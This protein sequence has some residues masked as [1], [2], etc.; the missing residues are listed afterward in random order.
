MIDRTR[1]RVQRASEPADGVLA[2]PFSSAIGSRLCGCRQSAKPTVPGVARICCQLEPAQRD[3]VALINNIRKRARFT[4]GQPRP[5]GALPQSAAMALQCGGLL[6]LQQA[7]DPVGPEQTRVS[8]VHALVQR[9]RRRYGEWSALPF[10]M[11]L[12]AVAAYRT[13]AGARRSA[14]GVRRPGDA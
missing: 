12:R 7:L 13:G 2:C 10:E 4:L 8:N 14:R 5:S 3:C 9:A 11:I 6:G 1:A